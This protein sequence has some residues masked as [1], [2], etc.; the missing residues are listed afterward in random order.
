MKYRYA[1]EGEGNRLLEIEQSNGQVKNATYTYNETGSPAQSG[2][3][4]YAYNTDQRPVEVYQGDRLIAE[5]AY[6]GFGERIKKVVHTPS[7]QPKITYYLY[8][9]H[10]LT[11]EAD[12]RGRI[13]AQY[14][15]LNGRP[16]AKLE[17][18]TI[19]AIHTDHL[20]TPRAVT[21]SDQNTVWQADYSPFGEAMIRTQRLTLNLRFPGQYADA[22][23]GTYYNYFRDYNP[24][25]GR[26]QTSD[27][28]GLR[29]GVN[30]YAYVGGNPV[31]LVDPLGLRVLLAEVPVGPFDIGGHTYLIIEPDNIDQLRAL[32]YNRLPLDDAGRFVLRAGPSEGFERT[33]R[34]SLVKS[35]ERDST[36]EFR[37]SFRISPPNYGVC[38][39]DGRSYDTQFIVD[40]L[41]A[42]ARY[43]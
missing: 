13:T 31:G 37:Q 38:F 11:A 9:G 32:G 7:K 34:G 29:G 28:I 19:Y 27:P 36:T 26:Y 18:R 40:L 39:L 14:L 10:S 1:K 30:T 21:D 33:H 25:T 20:G 22:E 23:T 43:D 35:F 5:Y 15:Y 2:D 12:E 4:R 3:L 17:G 24:S 42:Y 16:V 41:D 8:D 6:N